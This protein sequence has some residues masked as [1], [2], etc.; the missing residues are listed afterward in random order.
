M[1]QENFKG[2]SWKI[3][4]CFEGVLGAF[5]RS[6]KDILRKIYVSRKFF[7]CFKKASMKFKDILKTF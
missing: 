1:F 3:E 2:V 5:Q 4:G 6:P 7:M